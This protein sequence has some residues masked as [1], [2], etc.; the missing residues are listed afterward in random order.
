M[1]IESLFTPLVKRAASL[2]LTGAA[3]LLFQAAVVQPAYAHFPIVSTA[4]PS[5]NNGTVVISLHD[6]LF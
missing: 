5:C 2:F 3:A 1:K 4:I 6:N